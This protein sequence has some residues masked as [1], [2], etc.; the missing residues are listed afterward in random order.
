[1]NMELQIIG[2]EESVLD[3]T[4]SSRLCSYH[5]VSLPDA[6][7]PGA[8]RIGICILKQQ[9]VHSESPFSFKDSRPVCTSH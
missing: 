4:G 3:P 8:V 7:V 6:P 2:S 5:P 9:Q 1:M